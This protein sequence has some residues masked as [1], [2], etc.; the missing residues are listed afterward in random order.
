MD[1]SDGME[2]NA[3][4]TYQRG[5]FKSARQIFAQL[6]QETDSVSL[7]DQY[8]FNIASCYASDGDH[9]MAVKQLEEIKSFGCNDFESAYNKA[10]C[11]ISLK[12]A[13]LAL[14]IVEMLA[15]DLE[16]DKTLENDLVVQLVLVCMVNLSQHH[17]NRSQCAILESLLIQYK[18]QLIKLQGETLWT[19]NM[20]HVLFLMDNRFEECVQLYETILANCEEQDNVDQ[21]GLLKVDPM[22]LGN[23]CASY[24]LTGRNRDA[25]ELIKEVEHVEDSVHDGSSLS[26]QLSRES[27]FTQTTSHLTHL[28]LAI[29]T[30]YCVKG[31]HEFGLVRIF[32]SLEPIHQKLTTFAWQHTKVCILSTLDKHCRQLIYIKDELFDQIVGFLMQCETHGINVKARE[33]NARAT[34]NDGKNSVTYEA[35]YLRSVVLPLIHD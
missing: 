7:K 11:L 23:L 10:T 34:Q 22:V 30:L 9:L 12:R 33:G 31:N 27:R 1:D 15:Q 14:P 8:K 21:N 20:A 19:Q 24:I 32:K 4:A 13:D 2:K 25:E 5:D 35:R 16:E 17:L 18:A 3:T 29:G 28:N 6:A 26:L